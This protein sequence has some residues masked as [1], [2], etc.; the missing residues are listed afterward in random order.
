MLVGIG[1]ISLAISCHSSRPQE[2]VLTQNL[3]GASKVYYDSI[4]TDVP[5]TFVI[6]NISAATPCVVS[7][8]TSGDI[9]YRNAK[10]MLA[11]ILAG[12]MND[13][14]K[15]IRI[16]R[17]VSRIG[18]HAD[19][20]YNH[21][22]PDHVD[23]ISIVT[24]PYFMCGE[25]AGLIV[26]LATLTGMQAH[27]VGMDGHVVAEV[28]Y[29]GSWHMFDA[30]ENCVYRQNGNI[31][32]VAD[33]HHDLSLVSAE[34]IDY[35]LRDNYHGFSHYQDYLKKY[36]PRWIDTTSRI[37]PYTF[38]N[39]DLTLYPEDEI[40]YT[41]TPTSWWYRLWHK[42][43]RYRPQGTMWRKLHASQSNVLLVN[44]TA[45]LRDTLP[46]YATKL[47]IYATKKMDTKVYVLYQNRVTGQSEKIYLGSLSRKSQL[48]QEFKA[49][50]ES[51]IYYQY[52]ILFDGIKADE[53]GNLV[54]ERQFEFNTLTFPLLAGGE[55]W[56]SGG[57]SSDSMSFTIL[58][59]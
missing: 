55:K 57:T 46:Y 27:S 52:Q 53:L 11:G 37:H 38:P 47:S 35:S 13:E 28:K 10:T 42:R 40:H 54:I 50:V 33:L 12:A 5:V 20:D 6:K 15:A 56:L 36:V 17:F 22:L 26:N 58:K 44:N 23:P 31:V 51:D 19:Y 1:L 2:K 29:N 49:P 34:H 59:H 4:D 30:D 8:R 48:T 9:D 14:E 41:L 7:L 45:V 39:T 43:G 25:K 16:W 3:I 18:Y 32:S 24:F 21:Q